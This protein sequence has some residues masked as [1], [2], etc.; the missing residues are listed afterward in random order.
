MSSATSAT[1]STP[2]YSITT[3]IKNQ[4]GVKK[5]NHVVSSPKEEDLQIVDKAVVVKFTFNNKKNGC[6]IDLPADK[7]FYNEFY[8]TF[9]K[10]YIFA[11][12]N[13]DNVS[14]IDTVIGSVS[15]I[16]R[17]DKKIWQILDLKIL[18]EYRGQKGISAFVK[19]TLGTRMN[20]SGAYFA[21]SMNP[22]PIV[23]DVINKVM[24]PKLKFRGRMQIYMVSYDEIK[25]ALET[26]TSFYRSDIGYIDNNDKRI[27][28]DSKN[29]RSFK[30]L[31]LCH[32]C[33]YREY[34]F[35]EL[36]RGYLYCFS[37]HEE[38]EFII[39]EL[40]EKYKVSPCANANV[41]S[42]DFKDDWS[43]FVKTFEI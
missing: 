1:S 14:N 23:D 24:M 41:Y 16:Y 8:K 25:K 35:D 36:Q 26:L 22:N 7:L 11:L 29:N 42:N 43:R 38:N 17:Y 32:N 27:F 10:P 40:K 33:D 34:D 18:K 12:Y 6:Y 31:H 28:V 13:R 4:C 2:K 15:L 5:F 21:I 20:K 39:N 3:T 30:M 19:S 37:I 9:G